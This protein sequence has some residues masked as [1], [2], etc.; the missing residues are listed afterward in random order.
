[1]RSLT[2]PQS[3]ASRKCSATIRANSGRSQ[4]AMKLKLYGLD[5]SKLIS[6]TADVISLDYE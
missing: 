2:Y 6:G 1:M 4:A 5:L 3:R